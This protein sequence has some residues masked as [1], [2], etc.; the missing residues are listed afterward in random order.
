MFNKIPASN[1]LTAYIIKT[2]HSNISTRNK[3]YQVLLWRV[4]DGIVTDCRWLTLPWLNTTVNT[5]HPLCP[6]HPKHVKNTN[7]LSNLHFH[8]VIPSKP[9][10]IN[11]LPWCSHHSLIY[12]NKADHTRLG[13]ILYIINCALTPQ[14]YKSWPKWMVWN[15]IITGT[16]NCRKS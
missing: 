2:K 13:F 4:T 9:G 15:Q 14:C 8:S 6:L 12:V 1:K 16:L 3:Q 10:I 11:K 7:I 5:S